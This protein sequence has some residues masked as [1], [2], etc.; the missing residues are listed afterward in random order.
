MHR[1]WSATVCAFAYQSDYE[2]AEEVVVGPLDEEEEEVEEVAPGS[3]EVACGL[4]AAAGVVAEDVAVA[5]RGGG[6]G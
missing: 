6:E 4:G 2:E 1:K 5:E 3:C